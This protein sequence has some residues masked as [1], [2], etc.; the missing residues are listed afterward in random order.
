M[1]VT[2]N[3]PLSEPEKCKMHWMR[4]K[5]FQLSHKKLKYMDILDDITKEDLV[6]LKAEYP[7]RDQIVTVVIYKWTSI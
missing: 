6:P 1:T 4:A 5:Y 3:Q 7:R 2:N